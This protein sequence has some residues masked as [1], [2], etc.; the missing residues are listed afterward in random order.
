ML[1]FPALLRPERESLIRIIWTPKISG[2]SEAVLAHLKMQEQHSN[3]Q[4]ACVWV[5]CGT[6]TAISAVQTRVK[7]DQ[8]K[9]R[10]P[11][12]SPLA[13]SALSRLRF[14]VSPCG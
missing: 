9:P 7:R 3:M 14:A 10:T 6:Q 13:F 2:Y 5:T 1:I 11:D 8:A 4:M 12:S